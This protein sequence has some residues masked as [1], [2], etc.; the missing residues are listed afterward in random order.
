MNQSSTILIQIVGSSALNINDNSIY[1]ISHPCLVCG[2][3]CPPKSIVPNRFKGTLPST[4][5]CPGL[6]TMQ[7]TNKKC[8]YLFWCVA[9]VW[10]LRRCGRW[11]S[12]VFVINVQ[13]AFLFYFRKNDNQIS[14]VHFVLDI[15]K[16]I[17]LRVRKKRN[18]NRW[19]LKESLNAVH[20]PYQLP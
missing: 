5:F 9:V 1:F 4:F 15:G 10:F 2:G 14:G 12:F 19:N 18:A 20:I 7:K 11:S 17:K 8:T 13:F 16:R 6:Q 3:Q